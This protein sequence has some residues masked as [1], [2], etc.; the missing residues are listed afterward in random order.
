MIPFGSVPVASSQVRTSPTVAVPSAIW[1]R[2]ASAED[3][4]PRGQRV[5][6]RQH[7]P[8]DAGQRAERVRG[9][10][11]EQGERDVP[12]G[13][14]AERAARQIGHAI[15]FKVHASQRTPVGPGRAA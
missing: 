7:A 12:P 2:M 10:H 4:N 5:A 9:R 8:A 11:G 6:G 15:G 3:Q 1:V 13:Q 14:L